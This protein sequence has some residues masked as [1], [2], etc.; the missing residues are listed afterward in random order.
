VEAR[1]KGPARKPS[2]E[3]MPAVGVPKWIYA[4]LAA[5]ILIV[6]LSA[7]M[8]KR[9]RDAPSVAVVP[10]AAVAQR[11]P[12][13]E[14]PAPAPT[15]ARGRKADGWSVIVATYASRELAEKRI[16]DMM[17]RWPKFNPGVFQPR[18]E[19]THYLVVLGQNLS[20]DQAEELRKRA[21]DSGLP[22]DTYIKRVM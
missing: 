8:R 12:E 20:E 16:R 13:A 2:V 5:L 21:V 15:R 1:L 10:P 18:A 11:T 14:I 22:R 6:V 3:K 19:K 17:R 7:V 4:G 9:D